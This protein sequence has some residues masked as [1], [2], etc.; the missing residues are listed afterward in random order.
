MSRMTKFLKQ[1]CSFASIQRDSS[2]TAILNRYGEVQYNA[3]VELKCRRERIVKDVQTS[4]GAVLKSTNRYFVDE[5]V[6]ISADD[7]ID[8]KVV[9]EVEEYTNELGLTEGYECYV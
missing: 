5:S 1:T 6:V 2:G 3:P 8:G 4:N 7:M 9:L